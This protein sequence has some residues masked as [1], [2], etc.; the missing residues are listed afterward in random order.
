MLVNKST[1]FY[2]SII[3]IIYKIVNISYKEN[4]EN[5]RKNILNFHE[6]LLQIREN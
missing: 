4:I 5:E 6:F 1:S 2:A 3:P